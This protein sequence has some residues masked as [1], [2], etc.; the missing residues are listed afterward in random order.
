MILDRY[1]GENKWQFVKDFEN[2]F[3]D[4]IDPWWSLK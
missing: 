2:S 3:G 1:T 4:D